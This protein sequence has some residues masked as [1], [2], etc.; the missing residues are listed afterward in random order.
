MKLRLEL[1]ESFL[2]TTSTS[3]ITP[4]RAFVPQQKAR[5]G[6]RNPRGSTIEIKP[7]KKLSSDQEKELKDAWTFK[8]GTLTIVDLSCP[9]VDE[10]AACAL[11][12]IC[13]ELFLE[14]RN[15][16]GRVVALDEAHKVSHFIEDKNKTDI[17]QFL[18]GSSGATAFTEEL[19]QVIR[20]QRHL[21]TRVV[22]A[23]QEPTISPKLLE[24]CNF[25]LVHRFQSPEWFRT[26]QAYLAGASAPSDEE[27]TGVEHNTVK[28]RSATLFK[29]IVHLQCGQALL[30]APSAV[31]DLTTVPGTSEFDP[32]KL[33]IKYLR[34]STRQRITIDGG[35]S[36]M[37]E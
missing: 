18:T 9:F 33:G 32:V 2:R 25:T 28:S 10:N 34:V 30:F 29:Q 37:A 13:L 3:K 19:L 16:A 14:D 6:D 7:L 23:T 5:P 11:F 31:I 24:L 4:L 26:L 27:A 21:G 17:S 12:T 15:S 8:P 20:Q 35:R 36:I 22:I 1:L